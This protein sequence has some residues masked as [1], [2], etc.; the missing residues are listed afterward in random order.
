MMTPTRRS[1]TAG[2]EPHETEAPAAQAPLTFARRLRR[3]RLRTLRGGLRYPRTAC[4]TTVWPCGQDDLIGETGVIA[5]WLLT[6]VAKIVCAYTQP[7]H[8]VLLLAPPPHGATPTPTRSVK[9]RTQL[10]RDPYAGLLEAAWTV[11][12]LG[13][14]IQT[15]TVGSRSDRPLDAHGV[16]RESEA[17]PGLRSA[18]SGHAYLGGPRPDGGP[19]ADTPDA[20]RSPDRFDLII[21]ASGPR[22]LDWLRLADWATALT[23]NGILAIVT[24]GDNFGERVSDPAGSIVRAAHHA[25]LRYLD[26]IALLRIPVHNGALNAAASSAFESARIPDTSSTTSVRHAQVHADLLVFTRQH[27]LAE[28]ASSED[29]SDE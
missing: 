26:R 25:G 4:S 15:H 23:L 27:D 1:G 13:R 22:V 17:S 5:T 7:G 10:W 20:H 11:V 2:E 16:P 3:P 9:V 28:I 24:H 6:A 21:A 29:T 14:G 12:R 19:E 8:R 18:H